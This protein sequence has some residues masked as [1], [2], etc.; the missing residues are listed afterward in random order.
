M[1]QLRIGIVLL[2]TLI[3]GYMIAD[4]FH[5]LYTGD[6]ITIGG[7]LGP[8]TAVLA[9]AHI[10]YTSLLAKLIFLTAGSLYIVIAIDYAVNDLR[11]AAG[12][13]A[14]AIATLWYLPFGTIFSLA[15]LV[16]LWLEERERAAARAS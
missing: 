14:I 10:P 15:V 4:A 8:W 7:H 9:R 13:A 11:S 5:A 12:V 16:L 6:Y 2:A 1:L 3:G